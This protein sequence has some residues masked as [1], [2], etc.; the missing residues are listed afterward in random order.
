MLLTHMNHNMAA[1]YISFISHVLQFVVYDVDELKPPGAYGVREAAVVGTAREALKASILDKPEK[2][3]SIYANLQ[4]NL[5][6]I[7]FLHA[8]TSFFSRWSLHVENK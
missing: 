2:V 7:Y 4:M 8:A 6:F 5:D 3:S 1:G